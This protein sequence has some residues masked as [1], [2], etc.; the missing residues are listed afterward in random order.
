M[1]IVP[2]T[3]AC[4]EPLD[5]DISE[6]SQVFFNIQGQLLFTL[7]CCNEKVIQV[8]CTSV[9]WVYKTHRNWRKCS[10]AI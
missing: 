2:N 6:Q 4:P 8:H 5:D 9:A 1:I 7:L 10:R 3:N